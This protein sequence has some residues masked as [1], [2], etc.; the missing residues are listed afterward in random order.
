[1]D[2]KR[3]ITLSVQRGKDI[4]SILKAKSMDQGD[5]I[6]SRNLADDLKITDINKAFLDQSSLVGW[7]GILEAVAEK[8]LAESS[9]NLSIIEA[10]EF[11]R[12]KEENGESDTKTKSEMIKSK[13]RR[14]AVKNKIK[15]QF[16]CKALHVASRALEHRKDM[17]MMLGSLLKQEMLS[18]ISVREKSSSLLRYANKKLDRLNSKKVYDEEKED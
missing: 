17:L 12:L 9:E 6:E 14:E 4:N 18:D 10:R 8:E 7:W 3:R 15:K 11:A 5:V 13:E 2:K 16:N 1:M